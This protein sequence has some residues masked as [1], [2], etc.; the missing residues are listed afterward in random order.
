[1]HSGKEDF[2]RGRSPG[3][4]FRWLAAGM[5]RPFLSGLIAPFLGNLGFCWLFW[6]MPTCR[7]RS[8]LIR[9]T[10]RSGRPIKRC[11][12]PAQADFMSVRRTGPQRRMPRGSCYSRTAERSDR[13]IQCA[14][15]FGR[16]PA[17]GFALGRDTH[18]FGQQRIRSTLQRS[19]YTITTPVKRNPSLKPA[20]L[21]FLALADAAFAILFR[22]CRTISFWPG[23]IVVAKDGPPKDAALVLQ[24]PQHALLG[25]VFVRHLGGG[26]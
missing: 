21:S 17:A 20:L 5:P 9:S 22:T 12:L 16:R 2:P 25:C 3:G 11:L 7:F 26:C 18:L 24:N 23:A 4:P 14:L 13:G 15:I 1:M 8:R 19:T 6:L 10:R